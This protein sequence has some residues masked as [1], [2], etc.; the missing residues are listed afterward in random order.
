MAGSG[1]KYTLANACE[2]LGAKVKVPKLQAW[3]KG[4]R[5]S[6]DDLETLAVTLGLSPTWLLLGVGQPQDEAGEGELVPEYVPIGDTL[7]DLLNQLPDQLPQVAQVAGMTP[8]ELRACADSQAMLS[9]LT[10]ARLVHAYRVNANFLLAQ[11]GQPFLT[12]EQYEERGP[13]TWLREKRGDFAQPDEA[14]AT[15]SLTAARLATVERTMKEA[16][17]PQLAILHSLRAMLEGEIAKL[18]GAQKDCA[19]PAEHAPQANPK[20]AAGDDT[21]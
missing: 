6:A 5:P 3:K 2:L 13:L 10:V 16:G 12:E 11:V 15:I 1:L 9:G 4:Q 17:S 8:A 18:S 7:R 14:P 19:D 21:V 20:K